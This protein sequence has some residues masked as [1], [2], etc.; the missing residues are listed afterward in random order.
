MFWSISITLHLILDNPVVSSIHNN[1]DC[2]PLFLLLA[3]RRRLQSGSNFS[4][5]PF[6]LV[7]W[8]RVTLLWGAH[9]GRVLR[10]SWS[11]SQNHNVGLIRNPRQHSKV[12]LFMQSTQKEDCLKT[13]GIPH[14][15]SFHG[16]ICAFKNRRVFKNCL[17]DEFLSAR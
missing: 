9:S 10:G 2:L 15:L 17:T 8:I 5:L 6:L 13:D 11:G 7:K 16:L 4:F 3:L 14:L 12:R 1:Y